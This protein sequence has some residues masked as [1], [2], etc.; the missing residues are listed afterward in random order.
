MA[1][2][3]VYEWREWNR[4]IDEKYREFDELEDAKE[5][6]DERAE[7][8]GKNGFEFDIRIYQLTNY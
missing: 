2:W 1:M 4:C 7:Y 3:L 5:Y 8:L 6:A